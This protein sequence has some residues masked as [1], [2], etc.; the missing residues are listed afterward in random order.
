MIRKSD[1]DRLV[2]EAVAK[3]TAALKADYEERMK[4]MAAEY[5][6]KIAELQNQ[7]DGKGD[8]KD[9]TPGKSTKN[10]RKKGGTVICNSMEEAMQR[11]QEEMNKAAVMQD[12]AFGGGS[13]KLSSEQ[14]SAVNPEEEN[15]DDDSKVQS[16]VNP[17]GD[18]GERNNESKPRPE[19]YSNYIKVDKEDEITV[20]CYPDG[21]DENSKRYGK[22]TNVIWEL[23]L[24]K[25]KKMLV[26]LYR[27]KVNG[28]K[29]WAKMPNRDSLLKGTHLGTMYVV[30]LILNK[31]LNGM[32]ENRTKKSLEYVTGAD[33]PKQ[34]NNTL[35]NN[36]LT[37]IRNLFEETYR[38]HILI[39]SY[40]AV[41]E[42]VG[43]VFV[44]DNGEIHL[45]TRYF[46]HLRTRYFWGFRTSV[47]NLVYF[48][49]DKGSRSRE[50]IVNFLKEFIGTIQTD[51]ASM[52]K[53][54]EKDPTL[55]VTR[56]S[57]L[58]HIRRYFLKPQIY[59]V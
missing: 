31:Y 18:Y 41:D 9:Q 43:D 56:L 42:T 14:K 57:C 32:A 55:N 20:D 7:K 3:A 48:I 8:D 30:N 25:L 28:K 16:P 45:R 19:E 58:V 6:A 51:G 39:D 36:L 54:F 46:W 26:N 59:E 33:V 49:Y 29:V 44:D 35:V 47:T 53:I 52:Y 22:R 24:P 10:S 21:C 37:K 27:C 4:A 11:I 17:R 5:E 38:K 1:V 15:A 2:E 50:V 13:E 12:Q 40:L 34:T 23:S